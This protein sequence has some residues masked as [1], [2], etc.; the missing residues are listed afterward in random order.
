ML[1][2]SSVFRLSTF[3]FDWRSYIKNFPLIELLCCTIF[4]TSAK[5]GAQLTTLIF[6]IPL[7]GIESV[8]INSSNLEFLSYHKLSR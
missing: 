2:V 5:S 3:L 7:N 6:W 4:I 8:T 1:N